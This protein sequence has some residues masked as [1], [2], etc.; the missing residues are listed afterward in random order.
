MQLGNGRAWRRSSN[1]ALVKEY[2]AEFG[3]GQERS[4]DDRRVISDFK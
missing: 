3:D 1:A 4:Y 2:T